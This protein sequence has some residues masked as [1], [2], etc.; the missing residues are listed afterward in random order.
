[1]I[2]G[3]NAVEEAAMRENLLDFSDAMGL[4]AAHADDGGGVCYA[5]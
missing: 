3:F 1:M 2:L 5:G 4:L